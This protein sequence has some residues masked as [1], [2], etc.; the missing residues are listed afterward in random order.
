MKYLAALLFPLALLALPES[1]YR[2]LFAKQHNGR[3]EV[4]LPDKTRAD[5]ITETHAVEVEFAASWK[6][7]VG[8]ALNYAFQTGKKAGIVLVIE[9]EKDERY[10][11]MLNSL[12]L[13][14]E[15]PIDVMAIRTKDHQS[16]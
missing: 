15:L 12:V 4:T 3:T 5:I 9:S 16:N 11:I 6:N 13:H 8:Q 14:Y 10:L 1:H 2:D 7:S